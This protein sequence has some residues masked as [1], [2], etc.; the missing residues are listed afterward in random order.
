LAL[1]LAL[2]PQGF[3]ELYYWIAAGVRFDD[4]TLINRQVLEKGPATLVDR[5]RHYW[6]LWVRGAQNQLDE[7]PRDIGDMFS[8]SL[9][10][11]RTQI[12]RRRRSRGRH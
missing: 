2:P 12:G 11:L 8:R 10:V 7:I 3:G 4:V 9:L 1:H 6:R 5:N